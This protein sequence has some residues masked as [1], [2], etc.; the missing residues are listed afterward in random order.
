MSFQCCAIIPSH[1]H[2]AVIAEIVGAL[3]ANGL[4]VFVIDDGSDDAHQGALAAL[5]A[6]DDGVVVHRFADNRGKGA[7]VIKGVELATSAGFTHALQID[8]D[9]QHDLAQVPAMIA[10]GQT[11][12]DGL[13]RRCSAL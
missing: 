8:A 7:A 1:N 4:F 6:P 5:H 3:R 10:L 13:D 2:S 11:H 9:G 12:P